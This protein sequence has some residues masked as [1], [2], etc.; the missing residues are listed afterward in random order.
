MHKQGH[1]GPHTHA[2]TSIH[3]TCVHTHKEPFFV[4]IVFMATLDVKVRGA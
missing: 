3:H 4:L 1:I 2:H